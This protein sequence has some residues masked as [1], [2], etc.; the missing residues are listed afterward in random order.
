MRRPKR[1]A[2]CRTSA[3]GSVW[4]P[5][6]NIPMAAVTG[7]TYGMSAIVCRPIKYQ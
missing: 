3:L 2:Y 1:M 4:K 7:A 6:N 5:S